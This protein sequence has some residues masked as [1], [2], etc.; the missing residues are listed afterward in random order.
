MIFFFLLSI[1][2]QLSR[3]RTACYLKTDNYYGLYYIIQP[4]AA[5]RTYIEWL[6]N[7][8]YL[9]IM[10]IAQTPQYE[11]SVSVEKN[12]AYLRIIGFWRSPEQVP[13]YLTHWKKAIAVLKPGFTLITDARDMKIHPASVRKMH[14]EAQ[15]MI[16]EA[17]V[18]KVAELQKDM[19][20]EMQ[21]D[22]LSGETSMPKKN[23][24]DQIKAEQWLD[25]LVLA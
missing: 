23:F 10:T 2:P 19:I 18:L 6:N 24:T 11:L 16:I 7:K 3:F 25:S 5:C 22:G 4:A 21:L 14:E 1:I 15:L 13:D 8:F 20:T 12:R 17:G 9:S